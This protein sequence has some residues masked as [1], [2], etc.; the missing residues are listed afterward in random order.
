MTDPAVR[1]HWERTGLSQAIRDALEASGLDLAALTVEDLAPFDQFHGGGLG[2]T[3]RLATLGGLASGM[4]VL[5]VG[6]GLGGPART[7][8]LEFGCRVTVIDLTDSYVE[9]GR[10]LTAMV[11]LDDSVDLV[12]GDALDLPFPD[13]SF[14]AVWTQNSGMNIADKARLYAGF[15]RVLRPDGRLV[16]Q[17]PMAGPIEP[18]IYPLMWADD[19][20]SDHIRSPDDLRAVIEAAGFTV[21]DWSEVRIGPPPA[22]APRPAVTVQSLV[23]GDERLAAIM[24]ASRRNEDEDRVTMV[25]AVFDA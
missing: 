15:R 13:A 20:S 16:T 5:D 8:A 6:G 4:R 9:A 24:S 11:G 22:D 3:R 21:R 25:Q 10:M 19:P 7:L 2:F 1:D 17:E 14:D 12:V 23:M 18:R